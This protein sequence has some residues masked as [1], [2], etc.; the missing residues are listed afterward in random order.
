MSSG[1]H[2]PRGCTGSSRRRAGSR[3]S[4][5]S[6]SASSQ[7][8]GTAPMWV[9]VARR[10]LLAVPIALGV[11][12]ICFGLVFLAPGDPLASLIPGDVSPADLA[13]MRQLYGF[14]KPIPVQYALWLGP[15]VTG[16]LGVSLQTGP[17]VFAQGTRARGNTFLIPTSGLPLAVFL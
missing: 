12:V 4:R 8:V 14:D 3:T 16:D 5:R 13:K 10:L 7:P 9:Y 1:A 15:A 11:T 2:S 6:R 17:P